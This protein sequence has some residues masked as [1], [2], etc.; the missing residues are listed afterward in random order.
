MTNQTTHHFDLFDW[1][2]V[3]GE[4]RLRVVD[5]RLACAIPAPDVLAQRRLDAVVARRPLIAAAERVIAR[6][7]DDGVIA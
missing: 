3:C 7:E 5:E 4:S 1:C 2:E 6:L